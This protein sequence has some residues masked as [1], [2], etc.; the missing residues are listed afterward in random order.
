M[1]SRLDN[2]DTNQNLEEENSNR[3]SDSREEDVV[4]IAAFDH[5]VEDKAQL[6]CHIKKS[7]PKLQKKAIT[8]VATSLSQLHKFQY[9]AFCKYF[10]IQWCYHKKMDWFGHYSIHGPATNNALE[11]TYRLIYLLNKSDAT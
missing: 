1:T 5:Q 7:L 3:E 10:M 8:Q 9:E 2:D 6:K 11:S 4:K